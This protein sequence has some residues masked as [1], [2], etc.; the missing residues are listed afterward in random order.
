MRANIQP[1]YYTIVHKKTN[2]LLLED[3]KLPLYWTKKE[4]NDIC[5]EFKGFVVK[6][7]AGSLLR[8]LANEAPYLYKSENN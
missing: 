1:Y 3:H 8:D 7:I 6:K 5:S 2:R 4:A